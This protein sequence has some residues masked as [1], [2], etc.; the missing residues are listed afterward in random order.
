MSV[1]NSP[2]IDPANNGSLAG[3]LRFAFGKLMQNIDGMLPARV[4]QFDRAKNRVQVQ[5]LIAVVTTSGAQVSRPQIASLPVFMLGGGGFVLNFNLAP[6]DLGWVQA[7][8]RDIS[9]FLQTYSETAPNTSRV[10]NFSD[11][12]FIPNVMTGYT[13]DPTDSG[14]AVLQSL[15][16][17]VKISLGVGTI[18][19]SAPLV[20]IEGYNPVTIAPA[21]GTLHVVG[22][23]NASGSINPFTP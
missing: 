10:K 17:S 18:N 8:D 22:N 23:I 21:G 15:D 4:I 3:T 11:G 13:I 16:G 9:L 14:N 19:I 6:G 2:D 12:V 1:G 20:T 5:L 7:N